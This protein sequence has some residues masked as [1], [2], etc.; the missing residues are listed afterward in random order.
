MSTLTPSR[1]H[2]LTP[3]TKQ[4]K[5]KIVKMD[6]TNPECGVFKID[7]LKFPPLS[8]PEI[9]TSQ[10]NIMKADALPCL[11]GASKSKAAKIKCGM[12]TRVWH[13]GCVGLKGGTVHLLNK[14]ESNGW[15]CPK[16]FVFADEV[17]E[18][19]KEESIHIE[20]KDIDKVGLTSTGK[21]TDMVA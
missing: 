6:D 11:C 8:Q 3:E 21:I 10:S 9:T 13:G 4:N 5:E 14:L 2:T 7:D 15:V 18:A 12:C 16:C 19:F 20:P 1:K 17:I